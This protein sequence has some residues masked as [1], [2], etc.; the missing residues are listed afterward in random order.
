MPENPLSPDDV[1][2]EE[3][4]RAVRD[5]FLSEFAPALVGGTDLPEFLQWSVGRIGEIVGAD[6]ATVF[7]SESAAEDSG[8]SVRAGWSAPG[9][10]ALPPTL[11]PL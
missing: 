4:R 6:R 1:A 5:L 9:V 11:G 3:R 7:L 8:F 2:A 10:P